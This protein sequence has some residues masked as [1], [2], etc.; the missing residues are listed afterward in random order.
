L[1]FVI[2]CCFFLLHLAETDQASLERVFGLIANIP[3]ERT[4]P[5]LDQKYEGEGGEA[6]GG[7][8]SEGGITVIKNSEWPKFG[9]IQINELTMQYKSSRPSLTGISAKINPGEKIAIVGSQGMQ[10]KK[11]REE[12]ALRERNEKDMD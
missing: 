8:V 1:L 2:Y 11:N 12:E 4:S 6:R 5:I 3:S 9:E 7:R 10:K